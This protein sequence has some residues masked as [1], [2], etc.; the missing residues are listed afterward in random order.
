[1]PAAFRNPASVGCATNAR[2]IEGM[3]RKPVVL[4][5]QKRTL[6]ID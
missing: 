3:P 5:R 4:A 6:W 1:V 2:R